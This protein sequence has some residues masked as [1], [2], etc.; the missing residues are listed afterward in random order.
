MQNSPTLLIAQPLW[1]ISWTLKLYKYNCRPCE[2]ETL[3]PTNAGLCVPKDMQ[4]SIQGNNI[5][6]NEKLET[7]KHP[8]TVQWL[9]KLQYI[10]QLNTTQDNKLTRAACNSVKHSSKE[11]ICEIVLYDS[12][13]ME[14]KKQ[15][16]STNVTQ[17]HT[18][19]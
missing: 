18:H 12:I 2:L 10:H 7:L 8:P 6:N 16:N 9:S 4:K 3:Y 1:K 11:A 13:Y 5:E 15:A 17:G 14:F 19:T